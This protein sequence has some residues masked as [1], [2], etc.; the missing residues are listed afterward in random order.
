MIPDTAVATFTTP[1]SPPLLL[2]PVP[3]YIRRVSSV[4][5]RVPT[6]T[7]L[8]IALKVVAALIAGDGKWAHSLPG[9]AVS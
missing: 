1:G 8:G 2:T 6:G 9:L 7:K 4:Y 5:Q 3:T